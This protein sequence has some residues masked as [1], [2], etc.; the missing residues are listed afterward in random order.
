M[1]G[2]YPLIAGLVV[3]ACLGFHIYSGL[4]ERQSHLR[5]KGSYCSSHLKQLG[6][7]CH[8]YAS[9]SN[10]AFP[11]SLGTLYREEYVSSPL[12]FVCKRAITRLDV[13]SGPPEGKV[14]DENLS[15]CYVARLTARDPPEF[16]LAFDEEWNHPDEGMRVLT[17]GGKVEGGVAAPDL[18]R[19]LSEQEAALAAQGRAMTLVRPSW[20]TYPERPEY[21]GPPWYKDWRFWTAVCALLLVA[22]GIAALTLARLRS[23]GGRK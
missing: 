2:K 15:Y 14:P 8:L 3:L 18:H 12:V 6:F 13:Y 4:Y 1:N 5:H 22:G 9:E 23:P 21:V 19:R 7:G 10:E 16:V 11:P 20:S 17:V